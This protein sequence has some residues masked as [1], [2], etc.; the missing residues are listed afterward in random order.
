MR[1]RPISGE[2]VTGKRLLV[3]ADLN[4]PV[5]NGRVTD[6]TRVT[7]FAEGMK[8]LLARGARLVILTHFGRPKPGELDPSFSVDKLRPA[9]SEALGVPVRFSDTCAT[10]GA[11]ILSKQLADGEVLLCEN[12]RYNP[13][14]TANDA[15]FA[16]EL[17]R[18]GDLYVNDAFSCAHRAHASTAA[19]AGLLPAYAGPLLV[20]EMEALT[21]ALEAPERPSVALVGGAKV[22]T[23]IAVLK[24]LVGRLDAVI[25][26]GGMANTFLFARGCPMGRSLHEADQVATV[27]EIEALAERSRCEILLPEDVVVAREFKAGAPCETVAADQCAEDAMILDAGPRSATTFMARLN[28]AH[29]ILWNG[30][31]GAFE[32]PPFD[33]AT[34]AVARKAA[35]LCH[36][37]RA[38]AIA[39][40]GDTVAALN[41]A[42]VTGD[43]TYV[44]TAGGAFLEW[45]EGKTLPGIAALCAPKQAA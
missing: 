32:I 37:G 36:E 28:H 26:G 3:R 34:V 45:L 30:P 33:A 14:E 38:V 7:R 21:S 29:T 18:L 22:S 19:V 24:N 31:L 41:A 42:G 10:E 25:V 5:E 23:K 4:V 20:E 1:I 9:L 40:G 17:A 39:G 11:V 35:D 6:A 12:L 8:P 13:G 43:F 15:G 44:S 16:A 27:R 2:S